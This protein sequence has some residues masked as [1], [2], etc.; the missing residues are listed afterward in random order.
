MSNPQQPGKLYVIGV[1]PGDPELMTLKAV[2]LIGTADVIA[3]PV[4]SGGKSRA[5]DIAADCIT[6]KHLTIAYSLPMSVDPAPAQAAYDDVAAKMRAQLIAGRTVALLCEGDPFLYGSG[7]H[8][9]QRLASDFE[10]K[11]VPGVTSLTAS[12]AAVGEPLAIRN[13]VLKVLPGP[14]PADQLKAELT[15]CDSAAIIKLG[16]HFQKVHDVLRELSL[17]D[18]AMLI[19]N[20]SADEQSLVPLAKVNPNSGEYFAMILVR[21]ETSQ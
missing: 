14:L 6:P 12:A 20:A 21:R 11:V 1:G 4:T 16:R 3:Y 17:V 15:S 19:T 8:V 9:Y 13:E 18:H 10:A 2:R 7:T 5:R